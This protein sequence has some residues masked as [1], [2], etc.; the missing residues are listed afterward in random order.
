MTIR[1]CNEPKMKKSFEELRE[2]DIVRS[3][4]ICGGFESRCLE[5]ENSGPS[6]ELSRALP[7]TS[8]HDRPRI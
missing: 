6:P 2:E 5:T 1:A 4:E 7:N 8:R 3:A